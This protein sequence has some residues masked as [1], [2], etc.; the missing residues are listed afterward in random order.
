VPIQTIQQRDSLHRTLA[1]A[2]HDTLAIEALNALGRYYVTVGSNNDSALFYANAAE[3]R[4][5]P[6]QFQRGKADALLVRGEVSYHQGKSSAALA[7]YQEALKLY[8]TATNK[9]GI[10]DAYNALGAVYNRQS[11]FGEAE[12]LHRKALALSQELRDQ[13]GIAKAHHGLGVVYRGTAQYTQSIA[14]Y[15]TALALRERLGDS[16][17]VGAT[18]TSLATVL[19][20]AGQH[21][22]STQLRF[23]ALHIQEQ[24]G[25]KRAIAS[26][27]NGL[28]IEF[29]NGGK[30]HESLE[31]LLRAER[32]AVEIQDK[33]VLANVYT[34]LGNTS[35]HLKR[36]DAALEYHTRSRQMMEQMGDVGGVANTY[37]NASTVYR[38][39]RRFDEALEAQRKVLEIRKK[40]G[41]INGYIAGLV[42]VVEI[43][44]EQGKFTDGVNT[45][46][47][48]LRLADSANTRSRK[49]GVYSVLATCY[50]SL[51]QYQEALRYYRRFIALKDSITTAEQQQQ[52]IEL[53]ERYEAEKREQHIAL[54]A[55]EQ[56]LQQAEL[57]R[58][59]SEL[60]KQR[61]ELLIANVQRQAQAQSIELLSNQRQLQ[62]LTL[63]Q[64]EAAL[65]E[66]QLR[67]DRQ[68]QALRLASQEQALQQ[69]EITRQ[70]TVQF[71][72]AAVLAA[73][74]A[75]AL[76][77][78][79][80]YRQKERANAKILRQQATL[81]AQAHEIQLA[82]TALHE[83]NTVL[84]ALN[85]EKTEFL[86]VVAHDL[87]NPLIGVRMAAQMLI[88]RLQQSPQSKEVLH[89]NPHSNPHSNLHDN[90]I[91]DTQLRQEFEEQLHKITATASTMTDVV[92]TLLE[93]NRLETLGTRSGA[94][95]GI[96]LGTPF[97]LTSVDLTAAV[98]AVADDFY[99]RAAAKRITI[100]VEPPPDQQP[101]CCLAD[102]RAVYQILDNLVSNAVKFSLLNTT[103]RLSVHKS[104]AHQVQH[105]ASTVQ[106]RVSD[107]GAGISPADRE[108][109][110]GK[111][112]RLS[113]TPTAGEHSSGLGLAIV[114]KLSE[115]MNGRVWYE[116]PA[117]P[118]TTGATFVVEL[119]F[120]DHSASV[121]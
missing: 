108:R 116:P 59:S 16:A 120:D 3:Q 103:V 11:N 55:K 13:H 106:V 84:S 95:L 102:A 66:T 82:N 14:N 87:K 72:L 94:G 22:E 48:A 25:N 4:S 47:Q 71:A 89:S 41:E 100:A 28:G 19:R 109:L 34:N 18:L 5:A 117:S 88:D 80:L 68:A 79:R 20:D 97:H 60:D 49:R 24:L 98:Q 86:G 113:A 112:E 61:A 111:Y 105:A 101:L 58:Q 32:F 83:A 56:S 37:H 30:L 9:R 17:G 65:T 114:K 76:W 7:L 63:Q 31:Y 64:R 75:A 92:G 115:A 12:K 26:L 118:A 85:Q 121:R 52:T 91:N 36:F 107:E 104:P 69:A 6:K 96:G 21:T 81:E 67:A 33:N 54:L 8:E 2:K 99:D 10:A 50:D 27:L 53:K 42:S 110:F 77:L 70:R 46:L 39:Q 1:G 29:K 43:Y 44:V 90:A 38:K 51:G 15:R 119:P 57:K 78:V 73:V 35:E 23:R 45:A 74:V 40:T 62:T 93:V